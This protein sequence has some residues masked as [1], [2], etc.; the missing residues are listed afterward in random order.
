MTPSLSTYIDRV[1]IADIP[2]GAKL[3]AVVLRRLQGS[4]DRSWPSI[5]EIGDRAGGLKKRT[6]LDALASLRAAGFVEVHE[7][8]RGAA[9]LPSEYACALPLVRESAPAPVR[10]S[11]PPPVRGS[12][13][14]GAAESTTPWCGLTGGVVRESASHLS[15]QIKEEDQERGDARAFARAGPPLV[16][17][18]VAPRLAARKVN[19]YP[20]DHA[21]QVW[22][23]VLEGH[24]DAV[25]VRTAGIH[26]VLEPVEI[27]ARRFALKR[28]PELGGAALHAAIE[29]TLEEFA[30]RFIAERRATARLSG[31]APQIAPEYWAEA[32]ARAFANGGVMATPNAARAPGARPSQGGAPD[33]DPAALAAF[34]EEV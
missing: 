13:P 2:A 12:A 34:L 23:R 9:R 15:K 24:P 3:V 32:C 11:A 5:K 21:V 18:I 29:A 26:R 22:E 31:R 7:R 17:G 27:A 19:A 4:N 25:A 6:V 28:R 16:L 1:F 30:S 10:E 8:W 14:P 20:G 33:S